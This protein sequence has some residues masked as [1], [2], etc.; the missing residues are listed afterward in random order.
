M[1]TEESFNGSY[2]SKR[3]ERLDDLHINGLKIIQQ[4]NGF[5]FGIDAVL[6]SDYVNVEKNT[7][8][9]DL[10]TGTGILPLLLSAKTKASHITGIEIQPDVAQMAKRSVEY[11]KLSDKISIIEGDFLKLQIGLV[12]STLTL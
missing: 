6:L 5:C 1:L 2:F 9:V 4:T 8:I 7:K 10:G 3:G 11:N 12:Q